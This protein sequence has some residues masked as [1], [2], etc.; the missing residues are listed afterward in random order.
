MKYT[1]KTED[2]WHELRQKCITAS[3]AAVLIGQNPYSSPGKLKQVSEFKG[4]AFTLVGQV[5]EPVVVDVTNRVLQTDFQLYEVGNGG[6][7]FYTKGLLGAT[8]DAVNIAKDMLLE[9]KSTKPDT[10]LKYVVTP[11]TV[12][13]VQLQVQMYCTDIL[14][15]YLAIMSTDLSQKSQEISWPIAIYN[16]KRSNKLCELIDQEAAR[17][18][19]ADSFRVNSNVKRQASTLLHMC[20]TQI[21]K[22]KIVEQQVTGE[23]R[24]VELRELLKQT[25]TK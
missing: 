23:Q 6:K 2:E 22:P 5:L 4:N 12:Y 11:P 1:V 14:E 18:Y 9:C 19:S 17:F 10:F 7:V 24:K 8:P 16:V 25:S 21:Y 15:G 20:Y 13:L 3:E